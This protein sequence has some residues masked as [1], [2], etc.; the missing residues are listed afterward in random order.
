[1]FHLTIQKLQKRK[2][3]HSSTIIMP[4]VT[5][6]AAPHQFPLDGL[7]SSTFSARGPS[8]HVGQCGST[9]AFRDHSV[10]ENDKAF[11]LSV[12]LPGVKQSDISLKFDEG[13]LKISGTR[14]FGG[15]GQQPSSFVKS[16]ALDQVSLDT[17]HATANLA[18]G[19]L[20]VTV[21]KREKPIAQTIPVT[22]HPHEDWVAVESDSKVVETNKKG[23]EDE[24]K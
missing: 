2:R 7:F 22:S 8:C 6:T 4:I 23:D 9:A 18:D 20:V 11:Q 16:F 12:D 17:T 15:Q 5:F 24:K 14:Q 21:P 19:V 10:A 13:V 3:K 1:M